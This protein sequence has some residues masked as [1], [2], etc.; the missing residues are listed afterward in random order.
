VDDLPAQDVDLL[1]R[2][3]LHEPWGPWRDNLHAAMI[4]REVFKSTLKPSARRGH[5]LE[6]WMVI[7]EGKRRKQNVAAFA[8]ALRG[9]AGGV[10]KHVSEVK[11]RPV[12]RKRKRT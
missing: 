5:K 1:A 9:M 7:F 11:P 12:R 10:R 8:E 3:W 2:Y 4:A 6:P